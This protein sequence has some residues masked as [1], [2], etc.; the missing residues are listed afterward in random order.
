MSPQP[1]LCT[2]SV[3]AYQEPSWFLNNFNLW[4]NWQEETNNTGVEVLIGEYSVIQI[5]TDDGII[6]YTF[7]VDKHVFYPRLVSAIAE[8][9]YVLGAERNS[10]V[11]K[12]SSYAP[13]LQNLNFTNW[14]PDMISYTAQQDET[15]RSASHW[16]QWLFGHYRGTETLPVT[17]ELNPLFWVASIDEDLNVIYVKVSTLNSIHAHG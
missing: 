14:T 4:D 12:M 16:Q 11:V 3:L 8:G 7:P 1:R 9:V 10:E 5:D 2:D 6:D 13:S 15:V 17:G